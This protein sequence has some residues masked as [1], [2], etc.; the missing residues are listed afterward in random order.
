MHTHMHIHMRA[1]THTHARVHTH[2]HVRTCRCILSAI[3]SDYGSTVDAIRSAVRWRDPIIIRTQLDES[4]DADP[5]GI[6]KALM[7]ALHGLE[8]SVLQVHMHMC[9]M[10]MHTC[11]GGTAWSGAVGASSARRDLT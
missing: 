3:L 9:H 8:P 5:R 6:S 7:A 10:Y 11:H 4:S 2:M 1:C